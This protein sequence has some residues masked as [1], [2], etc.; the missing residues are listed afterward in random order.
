MRRRQASSCGP[1]RT[2]LKEHQLHQRQ[3]VLTPLPSPFLHSTHMHAHKQQPG[4]ASRRGT[5]PSHSNIP[6]HNHA[7]TSFLPSTD[8]HHSGRTCTSSRIP[9]GGSG[10]SGSRS[11]RATSW[12]S[13]SAAPCKQS[14]RWPSPSAMRGLVGVVVGRRPH[15]VTNRT[16]LCSQ[17]RVCVCALSTAATFYPCQVPCGLDR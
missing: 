15:P 1:W 10:P 17:R 16:A 4:R 14:K 12:S 13:S 8:G 7:P 9:L 3:P 11:P 6:T 2:A 5:R